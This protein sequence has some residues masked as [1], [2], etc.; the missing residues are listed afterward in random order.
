MERDGQDGDGGRGEV[1]ERIEDADVTR[2]R[3]YGP[4]RLG[5]VTLSYVMSCHASSYRVHT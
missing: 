2:S 5:N 1:G 4:A 3:M